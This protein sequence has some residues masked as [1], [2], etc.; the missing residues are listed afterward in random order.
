[1]YDIGIIIV[2]YQSDPLLDQAL[3]ALANSTLSSKFKVVVVE[4]RPRRI[5]RIIPKNIDIQF[6]PQEKNLGFGRAVN[7]ARW[8]LH[9]QY[10][11]ILNPDVQV[12][13]NTISILNDFMEKNSRVGLVVPKLLDPEGNVQASARKFYDLPTI[14]FRRT[15]LCKIFPN[16]PILQ[17]HLMTDWDHATI[18]EI[19][20]ALGGCMMVRAETVP[21]EVFD[22]RFFLYFEDVDLC[23]R[24]KKAGWKVVY[25]PEA[26]AIH[27]HRQKSRKNPFSRANYEHFKSWVKFIL[28]YRNISGIE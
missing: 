8:Q 27:E 7:L 4:N 2:D 22:P 13:Q 12:L 10:L 26:V 24:L 3:M 6:L 21:D 18:R 23:L 17:K 25:H 20:W 14:L 28:K 5:H 11:F 9:A 16:H 1:M 15:F 19:D